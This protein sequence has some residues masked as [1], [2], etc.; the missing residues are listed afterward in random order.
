MRKSFDDRHAKIFLMRWQDKHVGCGE[1]RSF[2]FALEHSGKKK[3]IADTERSRLPIERRFPADLVRAGKDQNQGG[4][5]LR[6]VR[7]RFE[8]KIAAFLRMKAAEEE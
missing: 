2:Q 1:R 7:E 3:P 4:I 8:Q 6:N 5:V